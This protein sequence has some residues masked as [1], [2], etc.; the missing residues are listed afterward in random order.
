MVLLICGHGRCAELRA[1]IQQITE[2]EYATAKRDVDAL[3]A[4]IGQPP[5]PGLQ[6]TLEEKSQQYAI[7]AYSTRR[8]W[9]P[10]HAIRLTMG[11]CPATRAIIRYLQERRLGADQNPKRAA[12]EM[13]VDGARGPGA[14]RPRGRPKGSK[15]R[16]GKAPSGGGQAPE[17][18][19]A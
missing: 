7:P 2:G 12:D 14:K 16:G 6:A 18:V 15:N 10:L 3:R 17:A 13:L 19:P 11:L 9:A 5:L 4:E 8:L 1:R